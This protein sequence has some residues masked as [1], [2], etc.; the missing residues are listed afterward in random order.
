MNTPLALHKNVLERFV[1]RRA[2]PNELGSPTAVDFT[3][4]RE[5]IFGEAGNVG[6]PQVSE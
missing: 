5:A 3:K 6:I 4:V 2:L 1:I